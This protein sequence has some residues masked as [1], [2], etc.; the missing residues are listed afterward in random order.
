VRLGLDDAASRRT[1]R[2]LTLDDRTEQL[3]GDDLGVA[4]VERLGQRRETRTPRPKRRGV[5][6]HGSFAFAAFFA[7]GRLAA[8]F[9]PRFNF[10]G[11]A[12]SMCEPARSTSATGV[13]GGAA[14][15]AVLP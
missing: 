2:R 7:R 15:D 6:D 8:F 14:V 10:V 5:L 9:A 1:A 3:A 4:V 13:A 12:A 11:S